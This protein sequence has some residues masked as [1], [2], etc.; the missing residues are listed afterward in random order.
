MDELQMCVS[1]YGR[2]V[3]RWDAIPVE[4]NEIFLCGNAN[5]VWEFLREEMQWYSEPKQFNPAIHS[6]AS[7]RRHGA[8]VLYNA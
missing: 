2:N 7:W 4:Y 3:T 6:I 1:L 8:I 5:E